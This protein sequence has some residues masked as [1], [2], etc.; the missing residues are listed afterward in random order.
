MPP[1]PLEIQ[2]SHYKW[3]VSTPI[4]R[5]TSDR[6]LFYIVY[7]TRNDVGL[8][9]FRDIEYKALKTYEAER[10]QA[11]QAK[12]IER[13]KQLG[14]F[15]RAD[16]PEHQ[17]QSLDAYVEMECDYAKDWVI[18]TLKQSIR[19][20]RFDD[21]CLDVIEVFRLRETNVK[22]ICVKLGRKGIIY[23]PWRGTGPRNKPK[24]DDLIE[25]KG[26]PD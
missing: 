19:S 1:N 21:L 24:D 20:R 9:T 10:A 12:K 17:D 18:E 7:G 13:T 8:K 22:D 23:E 11:K 3:V 25:L 5:P 4:D 15:D 14:L 6:E 16:L 2:K 26:R